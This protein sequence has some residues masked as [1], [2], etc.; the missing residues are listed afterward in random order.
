MALAR[1][2]TACRPRRFAAASTLEGKPPPLPPTS[3]AFADAVTHDRQIAQLKVDEL[4]YAPSGLGHELDADDLGAIEH[5]ISATTVD[6]LVAIAAVLEVTSAVLLS[7]LSLEHTG[8]G[9]C[10][11]RRAQ[12]RIDC[13]GLDFVPQQT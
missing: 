1:A 9:P 5:G 11:L 8:V 6:D 13:A 2:P 12:G 4:S 3:R 7:H 10:C